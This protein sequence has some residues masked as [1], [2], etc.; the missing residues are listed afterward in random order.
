MVESKRKTMSNT[1][2]GSAAVTGYAEM[3]PQRTPDDHTPL[4]ICAEMA[5]QAVADAGLEHSQIDGLLT[6]TPFSDFNILWPSYLCEYLNVKASYFD[7]VEMGGASAAGMVWRAASAINAG[8]CD[9]VLCVTGE[10]VT[11]GFFS[12]LAHLTPHSDREF[13]I[14]YGNM[15]AN[16]GYAM[17][18]MRHMHEYGTKPEHLAKVA[19]DQRINAQQNPDALFHGKEITVDDVLNSRMVMD[20]L[21]ILEIVAPCTGGAAMVVS[22]TSLLGDSP[23]CPVKLLGS[24]EAGSSLSIA[25][26]PSLTTSWIKP[27]AERAFVMAGLTPQQMDFIQPYD[28]YTIT[29]A[30]T[31]EDMGFC[32]KGEGGHFIAEHDLTWEG[33]LPCNTHGG[34]LSFGQP[35]QAGGMSHIIEAVRQLMGRAGGRQLDNPTLGLAHGNGG[36]LG[37]QVTL[38]F[39]ID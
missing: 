4:S 17:I 21:H 9:H 1:L 25:N 20:P 2:S 23:H 29:I 34:Q 14:P 38:I 24:G 35:G 39:G 15:P 7:T 37:E 33:D 32:K 12:R 11:R 30:I 26:A 13:E 5:R 22:R 27:A 18:A 10:V 31:L 8:M 6:N 3:K 28:C 19:V 36:I 16:P